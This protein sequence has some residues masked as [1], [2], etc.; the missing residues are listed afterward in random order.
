M[1]RTK[2]CRVKITDKTELFLCLMEGNWGNFG[3]ASSYSEI[4]FTY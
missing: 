4:R 1:V 2:G 3:E